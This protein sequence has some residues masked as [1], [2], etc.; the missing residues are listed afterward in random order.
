MMPLEDSLVEDNTQTPERLESAGCQ[1]LELMANLHLDSEDSA[2]E[3]GS[4]IR[5]FKA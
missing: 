4:A 5:H 1:V 3:D 2:V